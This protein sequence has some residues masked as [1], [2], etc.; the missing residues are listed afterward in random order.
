MK[1]DRQKQLE[2]RLEKLS[3]QVSTIIENSKNV[4]ESLKTRLEQVEHEV[5]DLPEDYDD[6]EDEENQ[7]GMSKICVGKF[8]TNLKY[9]TYINI[10]LMNSLNI[11]FYI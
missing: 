4:E 9:L 3:E 1:E 11:F 5:L 7:Q 2:L 8:I 6:I 10:Y